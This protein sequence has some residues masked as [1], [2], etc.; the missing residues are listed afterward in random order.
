MCSVRMI[1]GLPQLCETCQSSCC[2]WES[3]GV[4]DV[5]AGIWTGNFHHINFI[6]DDIVVREFMCVDM[7]QA[8][9]DRLWMQ[10]PD[11][12]E[13]LQDLV[14]RCLCC[15]LCLQCSQCSVTR[16]V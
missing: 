7:E 15:Q 11:V 4:V 13:E 5:S 10:L 16:V 8:D 9:I 12:V 3:S 14:L 1:V 6:G 2:W